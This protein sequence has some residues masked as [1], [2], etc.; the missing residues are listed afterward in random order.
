MENCKQNVFLDG[1]A[2][3]ALRQGKFK[4]RCF[5]S[6][7][8]TDLKM[9]QMDKVLAWLLSHRC[10]S[11]SKDSFYFCDKCMMHCCN[12]AVWLQTFVCTHFPRKL[13]NV[14]DLQPWIYF[15]SCIH[16]ICNITGDNHCTLRDSDGF[17]DNVQSLRKASPF[18]ITFV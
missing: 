17:S 10:H 4:A 6:I 18:C 16:R 11:R 7:C 12:C 5:R 13:D 15:W 2:T 1:A 8:G 3:C 14:E 9:E